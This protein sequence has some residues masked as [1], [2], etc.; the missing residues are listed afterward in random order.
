ML[1][2][3]KHGGVIMPNINKKYVE[4]FDKLVRDFEKLKMSPSSDSL[5]RVMEGI[6][7]VQND[8]RN[9]QL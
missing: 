4:D 9:I 1:N 8:L 5:H 3:I 7:L 6:Q 2:I